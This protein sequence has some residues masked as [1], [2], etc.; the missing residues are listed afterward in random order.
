[1]SPPSA[2]RLVA[3]VRALALGL[4][5]GLAA[6][7][8]TAQVCDGEPVLEP[9]GVG[10]PG[11]RGVPELVTEGGPFV[12][13]PFAVRLA[14]GLPDAPG[15]LV[16]GET[17]AP[18]TLPTYGAVLWPT[19]PERRT[20]PYFTDGDGGAT[21]FDGVL[22]PALCGAQ[23]VVQA[24]VFDGAAQGGAAFSPALR[25]GVGEPGPVIFPMQQLAAG[26]A[27]RDAELTDLDDDGVLDI[28]ACDGSSLFV[29][30]GTG[31]GS[32]G[33]RVEVPGVGGFGLVLDDFDT[34]GAPDV[35]TVRTTFAG[36]PGELDLLLGAGDGSFGPAQTDSVVV[37]PTA[38]ATGDFDQDGLPDV[39]VGSAGGT[40]AVRLGT[41]DGGFGPQLSFELVD[42]V[43]SVAVLDADLDG[44]L[45]L[46]ISRVGPGL[47]DIVLVRGNG[48]GTFGPEEVAAVVSTAGWITVADVDDDGVEDIVTNVTGTDR[49]HV[50]LGAG[51]GTFV[52]SDAV[53][54]GGVPGRLAVGHLDADGNL[55]IVV[56]Q[57][58]SSAA[59]L[60]VLLGAG[61]GTFQPLTDVPAGRTPVGIAVGDLDHDGA[62]DL[63][64]TN[65]DSGFGSLTL[66][67]GR[68]DG[69]F[70]A[71]LEAETGGTDDMVLT[72]LDQDGVPDLVG[73]DRPNDRL[74]V[75]LG[76][77]DGTFGPSQ[78][79]P[80][81]DLP[82]ALAAGDLDLDGQPDIVVANT[83][84]DSV[85]VLLGLGDGSLAPQTEYP[86]GAGPSDVAIADLDG[87]GLPDL[88]VVD[89]NASTVSLLRGL[90][91]GLFG[92]AAT[93]DPGGVVD[94][95]VAEDMD[96]DGRMDL[97]VLAA[98]I[99][100]NEIRVLL[101]DGTGGFEIT[102]YEL[103]AQPRDLR[104]GDLDRDG[105]PDV[106]ASLSSDQ[107]AVLLGDG[108]GGLGAPQL[109]SSSLTGSVLALAD[110]DQDGVLDLAF[111]EVNS[112]E[113]L[114]VLRGLGDGRFAPEQL[115]CAREVA[116]GLVAGD[117]D[118]D[119]MPDLVLGGNDSIAVLLNQLL[120]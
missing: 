10:T 53:D 66:F 112:V 32:F 86:V 13:R 29:W 103:E 3:R 59:E 26:F 69:T 108:L 18:V 111:S 76:A 67:P 80:V 106:V 14:G 19:G 95:V 60:S 73:N 102:T 90:G 99:L 116:E 40:V 50:L 16:L 23:V 39:V 5:I 37:F 78:L 11:A 118:G 27:T 94:Q 44:R 65:S 84:G 105:H 58:T 96:A 107:I 54:V 15:L 97:V 42:F 31:D 87:D 25:L 51:D 62:E 74:S 91:D 119:G 93:I 104:V 24:V 101:N 47:D 12:D 68:G 70:P 49:V 56:A 77:G 38:V 36:E 17:A 22:S 81:G 61:D 115:H 79:H 88:A 75:V 55:D 4:G 98:S 89:A 71:K 1:M 83:F 6:A 7:E 28:V 41:G 100:T 21:L 8:G 64:V 63:V 52:E 117:L 45:D 2:P 43:R 9:L 72:D 120:R 46:L 57:S 20:V 85:S 35:L 30:R 92:P 109:Q 114:A 82:T 110:L 34:D 33:E 48:D 113:A